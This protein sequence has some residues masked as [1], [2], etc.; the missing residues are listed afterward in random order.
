MAKC[1]ENGFTPYG[2]VSDDEAMVNAAVSGGGGRGDREREALTS[3]LK[4]NVLSPF[5]T[6]GGPSTHFGGSGVDPWTEGGWGNRRAKLRG[7]GVT[8]DDWMYRTALECKM[9][10]ATLRQYREEWIGTLEGDDLKGWVWA[11]E[12]QADVDEDEEDE[13]MDAVSSPRLD[14]STLGAGLKPPIERKRSALSREVTFKPP[15]EMDQVE[16]DGALTPLAGTDGDVS[17]EVPEVIETPAG[18]DEEAE[19]PISAAL[20]EVSQRSTEGDIIRVE[21]N[22]EVVKRKA[23]WSFGTGQWQPGSIRAAYEVSTQLLS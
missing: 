9:I 5:Y 10:D 1:S 20:T 14:N 22:E 4:T 21:T 2:L 18:Q 17:M 3:T 16:S 6:L 15:T 23:K 7:Y 19:D 8:E 12:K 11:T 13:K